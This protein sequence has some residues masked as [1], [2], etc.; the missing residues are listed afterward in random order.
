MMPHARPA[1]I[2]DTRTV[3]VADLARAA[4]AARLSLAQTL[5]LL[6]SP[7]SGKPLT[8]TASGLNDGDHD[9]PLRSEVPLLLPTR[10]HHAFTDRLQVPF[11][12]D[13]DAFMQYFLLASIK[14]SGEINAAPDNIHYQ[15]HLF[16]LRTLCA[17][18]HGSVL[19][20]GCDDPLIGASLLP[21]TASYIGLD[22][23]CIRTEPFRLIGVGE[24]LPFADAALD[25]ALFNTSLDHIM[26]WRRGLREAHRVIKPGG[27]LYLCSLVWTHNAD[28]MSDAVH[29]HHF[30]E[31]E[32]IDALA[33]MTIEETTR[34]DYKGDPHRYGL[35]LRATKRSS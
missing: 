7:D 16:R 32:L 1:V 12:L 25:N 33:G 17:Q 11:A 29:F 2:E 9:Y 35:Y 15:R 6:A 24:Y 20:I 34:Y 28:L 18:A 21:P 3:S 4:H 14:Q 31:S 13:Y 23:F 27:S 8:Q 19:D 5:P 30:R 22:P 26:D 10:L